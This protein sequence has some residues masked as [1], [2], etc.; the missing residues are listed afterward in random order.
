MSETTMDNLMTRLPMRGLLVALS[1]P[2]LA[3]GLQT[4]KL[5]AEPLPSLM[6]AE[7]FLRDP[8]T[9]GQH[10][11]LGCMALAVYSEAER[12]PN[13]SAS[14]KLAIAWVI[15]NR[16]EIGFRPGNLPAATSLCEVVWAGTDVGDPQ[17]SGTASEKFFEVKDLQDFYLAFA[18]AKMVYEGAP[19]ALEL[20]KQI[21]AVDLF[22]ADYVSP[23]WAE[24]DGVTPVKTFGAHH[25]YIEEARHEEGREEMEEQLAWQF[26]LLEEPS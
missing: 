26:A 18:A 13:A 4:Q 6:T 15:Q 21:G 3:L 9:Y 7:E 23:D 8:E 17:F 16:L 25:F 19:I 1:L 5:A 20:R 11:E 24:A 2:L 22:H 10:D 12:G 14:E